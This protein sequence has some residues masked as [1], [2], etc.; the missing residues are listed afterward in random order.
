MFAS[1]SKDFIERMITDFRAFCA[2]YG[3]ERDKAAFDAAWKARTEAD[4]SDVT[5]FLPHY[6]GSPIVHGA[7]G[8][9]SGAKGT[10]G[11]AAEAGYHLAPG[12]LPQG[13]DLWDVLGQGF[14]LL[15][16]ADDPAMRAGFAEA[17]GAAGVPLLCQSL[18]GAALRGH[19]QADAILVRPDHFIAWAGRKGAACDPARIL[20]RAIGAEALAEGGGA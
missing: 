14:T 13:G 8:A 5:E 1:V 15:D 7:P 11:F 16:L 9:T 19:Y 17:A 6:A 2:A 12:P 4:D 18:P 20:A 10:H 3:P